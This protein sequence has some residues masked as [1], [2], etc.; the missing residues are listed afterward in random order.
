MKIKRPE[1]KK[2]IFQVLIDEIQIPS[3]WLWKWSEKDYKKSLELNIDGYM[4]NFYF[5]LDKFSQDEKLKDRQWPM[6]GRVIIFIKNLDKIFVDGLKNP[7]G[8][9]SQLVAEKIYNIYKITLDKVVSYSRWV[10]N[11]PSILDG[12]PTSFGEMFGNEKLILS[13]THVHWREGND[14]FKPFQPKIKKTKG[15]INPVFKSKNLL[16][17]EKWQKVRNFTNGDISI[18]NSEIEELLRIKSK[19]IWREKR[20]AVIETAALMEVIIR[21]KVHKALE[22]QGQSKTKI[23]CFNEEAGFSTLLNLLLPLIL[24]RNEVKKYKKHIDNLDKLRKIRN[25]IMHRN[26]KNENINE[27]HIILAINSAIKIIQILNK[28]FI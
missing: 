16:T 11:L 25:N 13:K 1:S 3:I 23:E 21:N 19:A 10:T 26:I 15:K 28:K 5:L 24:T 27:E 4:V 14:E 8:K 9:N 22:K 20:I 17:V 6:R 7:A 12:I 2:S 18:L